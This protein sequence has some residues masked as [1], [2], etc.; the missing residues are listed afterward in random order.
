MTNLEGALD[1]HAEDRLL[2]PAVL[3]QEIIELLAESAVRARARVL[4]LRLGLCDL[5]AELFGLLQEE[6]DERKRERGGGRKII[7]IMK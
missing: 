2:Q 1:V 4:L 7:R 3:A 6:E 5:L